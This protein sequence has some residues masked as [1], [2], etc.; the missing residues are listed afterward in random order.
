M[1]PPET[2]RCLGCGYDLRS[3]PE[4]R[5][6]ECGR[7]F[8]PTNAATYVAKVE[9]GRRYLLLA[10]IAIAAIALAFAIVWLADYRGAGPPL[11]NWWTLPAPLLLLAGLC[12]QFYVLVVSIVAFCRPRATREHSICWLGAL[13]LGLLTLAGFI[14]MLLMPQYS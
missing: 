9:S 10:S 8:D 5:C 14:A 2:M 12:L 1:A 7:G 6:P 4:N 13:V 11:G 3:L